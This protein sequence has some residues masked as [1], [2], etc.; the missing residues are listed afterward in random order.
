MAGEQQV[1]QGTLLATL[2]TLAK[3]WRVTHEYKAMEYQGNRMSLT[4]WANTPR[5]DLSIRPKWYH[6]PERSP[7]IYLY[8]NGY[9]YRGE[10]LPLDTWTTISIWYSLEEGG[11]RAPQSCYLDYL[12]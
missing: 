10:V 9:S 8:V 6:G 1:V 7:I 12:R 3:E 2:P 11:G 4:L 5:L